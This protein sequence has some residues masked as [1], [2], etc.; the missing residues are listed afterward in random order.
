MIR[1]IVIEDY[2]R[3]IYSI[4]NKYSYFGEIDDLYQVGV[5]GLLKAFD[6]Y[7]SSFDTK[8]STYAHTYI[9]GEVLKYIR[10]NKVMRTSR[11]LVKLNNRIEKTREILMQK[12]MRE[13]SNSEIASFL[14]VDEELVN[15]AIVASYYVKSLDYELNDE[16]KELNLYDSIS[17]EEKGYSSDIIDLRDSLDSLSDEERRLIRYRYFDDRTQSDIS[18]ELGISQVKV[19]RSENK[20]LRKLRD[21]LN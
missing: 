4:I 7:N 10:E 13:V 14:E 19:S 8:F 17:F 15:E 18:N 16:G 1:D 20:I 5:V 6:N 12:F 2:D 3:L 21:K 11:E 9:L